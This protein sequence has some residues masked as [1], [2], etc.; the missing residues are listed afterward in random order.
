MDEET[1]SRLFEP[2]FTTK[3]EGRGAGLGLATVYDVVDG[4]GGQILVESEVGKG[5]RFRVYLPQS[6]ELAEPLTPSPVETRKLWQQGPPLRVLLVDDED[7]MRRSAA[8]LLRQ[9]GHQVTQAVNGEDAVEVYKGFE[10][11]PDVVVLDMDMPILRGD[12]CFEQLKELDP[13]VRAIIVSGYI[14]KERYARLLDAGVLAILDKPFEIARL[15]GVLR[16]VAPREAAA[17]G[18][19]EEK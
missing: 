18:A 15:Q 13:D 2:F 7:V 9:I 17:S 4:H 6:G 19:P 3:H 12:E 8:R 16:Q 11:R 10:P 1:Q 5:T 14:D